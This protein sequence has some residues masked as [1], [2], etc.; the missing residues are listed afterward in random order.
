MDAEKL[1]DP[2]SKMRHLC[3]IQSAILDRDRTRAIVD[4]DRARAI[5]DR[6][7]TKL[8]MFYRMAKCRTLFQ[9]YGG[10]LMRR[11]VLLHT[12]LSCDCTRAIVDRDR[13]RAALLHS[14]LDMLVS[15]II[16]SFAAPDDNFGRTAR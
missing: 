13:T 6:D 16:M 15:G 4:S 2:I 12:G 10:H 5:A 9:S 3:P 14:Y 7:C 11:S 1:S 8:T